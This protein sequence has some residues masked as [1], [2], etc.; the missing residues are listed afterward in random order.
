MADFLIEASIKSLLIFALAM[1]GFAYATSREKTEP[2]FVIRNAAASLSIG[3]AS[4]AN[5][6]FQTLVEETR[7]GQ[8]RR[9]VKGMAHPR[10]GGSMLVLYC[11]NPPG[12]GD[13]SVT[14]PLEKKR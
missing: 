13:T 4:F 7:D 8:T 1:G 3:E 11:G 9:L 5:K 10:A 12:P 14:K 2:M 6:P